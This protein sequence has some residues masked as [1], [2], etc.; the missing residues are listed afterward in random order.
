[1]YGSQSRPTPQT[2]T[3][4]LG[5]FVLGFETKLLLENV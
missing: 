2:S 5:F 3:A 1:M 4:M